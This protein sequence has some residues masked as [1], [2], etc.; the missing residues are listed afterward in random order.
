MK[1]VWLHTDTVSMQGQ[2]SSSQA[3]FDTHIPQMHRTSEPPKAQAQKCHTTHSHHRSV[4]SQ[5]CYICHGH[6]CQPMSRSPHY[7]WVLLY[8]PQ[9]M[10]TLL[11]IG[12]H[13]HRHSH[14]FTWTTLLHDTDVHSHTLMHCPC[15]SHILTCIDTF[16]CTFHILYMH[17]H[18]KYKPSDVSVHTNMGAN[19][20]KQSLPCPLSHTLSHGLTHTL[21]HEQ[22]H[23]CTTTHTL[24]KKKK[25]RQGW[26]LDQLQSA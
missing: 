26:F 8:P 11:H 3:R 10:L 17:T 12:T 13:S 23:T 15:S 1:T 9:N 20:M 19:I 24:S 25:S 18:A 21:C 6:L 16:S 4:M 2:A 22:T 7:S 14:T 5:I